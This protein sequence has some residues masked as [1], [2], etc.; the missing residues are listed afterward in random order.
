MNSLFMLW[1]Q[2]VMEMNE[3]EICPKT[4]ESQNMVSKKA[5]QSIV[6]RVLYVKSP[7]SHLPTRPLLF[8]CHQQSSLHRVYMFSFTRLIIFLPL[9]NTEQEFLFSALLCHRACPQ[10]YSAPISR[11]ALA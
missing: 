4:D 5:G 7:P 10:C 1:G 11:C 2:L 8:L 6:F 9:V 3:V